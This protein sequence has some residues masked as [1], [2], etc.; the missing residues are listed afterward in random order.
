MPT[1]PL[2]LDIER[3][4]GMLLSARSDTSAGLDL[5]RGWVHHNMASR[6]RVK[7]SRRLLWIFSAA[8]HAFIFLRG[9]DCDRRGITDGMKMDEVSG[10][11]MT[12]HGHPRTSLI[13]Q[14][15]RAALLHFASNFRWWWTALVDKP[16]GVYQSWD[17]PGRF[18]LLRRL[19]QRRSKLVCR[20]WHD[21]RH[22]ERQHL[23]T[24]GA[25]G[26]RGMVAGAFLKVTEEHFQHLTH[27]GMESW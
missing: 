21:L 22:R 27:L 4:R 2:R 1:Q 25:L 8:V 7:W 20:Q 18:I 17:P 12:F 16:E 14:K 6:R 5:L 23:Y 9:Q 24:G 15:G 13:S 26:E 19:L 11:R 10:W 3:S